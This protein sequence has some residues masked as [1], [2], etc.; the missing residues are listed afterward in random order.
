M[1]SESKSTGVTFPWE[2]QAMNGEEMPDRLEYPDQILFLSLRMLYAQLKQGVI[3]RPTA[4]REKK[5]LMEEHQHYGFAEQLGKQWVV[6]IKTTEMARAAF[7]KNPS[8]ENGHNLCLAIED[9]LGQAELEAI[10]KVLQGG[11]S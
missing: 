9:T 1:V 10:Q 7:R 5:K 11:S 2:K 8:V 6:A 4:I 3:D